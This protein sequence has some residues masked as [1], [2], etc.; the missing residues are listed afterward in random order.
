M[1]G[2]TYKKLSKT[3]ID[4]NYQSNFWFL[5]IQNIT[6]KTIANLLVQFLF[7]FLLFLTLAGRFQDTL[8]Q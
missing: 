8:Y 5:D 6:I 7:F 1:G 3:V 2:S 4:R